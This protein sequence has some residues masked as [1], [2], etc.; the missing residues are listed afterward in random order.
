MTPKKYTVAMAVLNSDEEMVYICSAIIEAKSRVEATGIA[1]L[2][3]EREY[4]QEDGYVGHT[5]SI[6]AVDNLKLITAKDF[7]EDE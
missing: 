6:E 4:P 1:Q 3:C 2:L 5:T 7:E